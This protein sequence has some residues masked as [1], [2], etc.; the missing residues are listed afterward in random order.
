MKKNSLSIL[1]LVLTL[2]LVL[3]ACVRIEVFRNNDKSSQQNSTNATKASSKT[4]FPNE[5]LATQC[6]HSILQAKTAEEMDAF[7][8]DGTKEKTTMLLEHYPDGEANITMRHAAQY[9]NYDIFYYTISYK[10]VDFKEENITILCRGKTGYQ[11]CLED[12][13]NKEIVTTFTCSQCGGGGKTI[14]SDPAVCGICGGTGVQ[15]N[16][17]VYFDSTLNMWMG[18]NVACSG[19]GG[20]G[21]MSGVNQITCSG[22]NGLG[23]KFQ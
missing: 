7:L 5:D 22:C 1:C 17:N 20:S 3:C 2:S 15:W 8:T 9:K 16:P 12:A 6:M 14:T 21:Q 11:L 10:D 13:V 19:C 18:Q 4:T 23:L